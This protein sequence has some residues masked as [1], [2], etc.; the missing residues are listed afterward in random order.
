M[1]KYASCDTELM[2]AMENNLIDK[3]A[4]ENHNLS[5]IARAIE[6]L[7][8]AADIFDNANMSEES[9]EVTSILESLAGLNKTAE[10]SIT[11]MEEVSAIL[12]E[13]VPSIVVRSA[14][15]R[16]GGTDRMCVLSVTYAASDNVDELKVKNNIRNALVNTQISSP[17]GWFIRPEEVLVQRVKE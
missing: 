16:A 15:A 17:E 11:C 14:T 5:K 13:K 8:V 10:M 3:V 9:D 12:K 4:D 1:F 2:R 6:Y 7:S